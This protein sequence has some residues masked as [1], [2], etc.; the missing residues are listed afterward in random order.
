MLRHTRRTRVSSLGLGFQHEIAGHPRTMDRGYGGPGGEDDGSV[1]GVR[2]TVHFYDYGELHPAK[3][4]AFF[5]VRNLRRVPEEWQRYYHQ[6]YRSEFRATINVNKNWDQFCYVHEGYR[7]AKWVLAK[8]GLEPAPGSIPEPYNRAWRDASYEE[9]AWAYRRSFQL[10]ELQALQRETCDT[11]GSVSRDRSM[12]SASHMEATQ[13]DPV[14]QQTGTNV[15]SDDLPAPREGDIR[16]DGEMSEVYMMTI[17]DD[18]KWNPLLRKD[19]AA[20]AK[21]WEFEDDDDDEDDEVVKEGDDSKRPA[22]AAAESDVPQQKKSG[23]RIGKG[24]LVTSMKRKS[25]ADAAADDE[26]AD[27]DEDIDE[28]KLQQFVAAK[29][30]S[31]PAPQKQQHM[32]RGVAA[33]DVDLSGEND[34]IAR[35]AARIPRSKSD[36]FVR[37]I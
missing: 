10:K 2:R 5:I 6:L 20:D 3:K 35:P 31:A 1:E 25:S 26:F 32:S 7:K 18:K 29:Q 11:F 34:G 24:V 12:T 19:K 16:D 33:E 8:Y 23:G 36:R 17:Q 15:H 30:N 22:S 14:R 27:E 4:L 21:F 13:L 28:A 9:R 37:E